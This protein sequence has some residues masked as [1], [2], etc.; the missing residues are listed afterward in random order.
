MELVYLISG[1]NA[2]NKT[3]MKYNNITPVLHKWFGI[4]I[5]EYI[6]VVYLRDILIVILEC[7]VKNDQHKPS[8]CM[9][10]DQVVTMSAYRDTYPDILR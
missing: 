6:S 2:I 5:Y 9:I 4:A 3:H 7:F 1:L 8:F 10:K